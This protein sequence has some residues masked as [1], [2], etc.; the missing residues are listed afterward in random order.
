MKRLSILTDQ[1]VILLE[2]ARHTPQVAHRW[3]PGT[4]YALRKRRLLEEAIP[5][6]LSITNAGLA[7][8]REIEKDA[9]L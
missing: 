3:N 7:L 4:V 5:G 1:G 8:L 2:T 9:A 6:V